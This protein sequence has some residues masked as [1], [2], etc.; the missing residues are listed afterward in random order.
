MPKTFPPLCGFS[1]YRK[2]VYRKIESDGC[3]PARYR[4]RSDSRGIGAGA[5]HTGSHRGLDR[6]RK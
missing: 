5:Y 4:C 6:G 1:L 2:V 3:F